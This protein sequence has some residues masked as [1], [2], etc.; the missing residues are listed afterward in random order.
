MVTV[1]MRVPTPD[2]S[3]S[4]WWLSLNRGGFNRLDNKILNDYYSRQRSSNCA[5]FIA[6]EP[7]DTIIDYQF[8]H[9][10]FIVG[11]LVREQRAN[12]NQEISFQS[13][14]DH[15]CQRWISHPSWNHSC[16]NCNQ[17]L[18]AEME[19]FGKN[20]EGILYIQCYNGLFC[21]GISHWPN[22]WCNISNPQ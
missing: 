18:C 22:V 19:R 6:K 15:L 9:G 3:W 12:S 16:Y 10:Q 20:G 1:G 5:I 2:W 7:H 21:L 11:T 14:L 4:N 13:S 17:L 8:D